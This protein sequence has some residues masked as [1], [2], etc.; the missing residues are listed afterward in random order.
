MYRAS[1]FLISF[2]LLLSLPLLYLLA[3]RVFPPL[4]P[5][6]D[7]I[8]PDDELDDLSLLRRASISSTASRLSSSSPHP[9]FKIAFLFLTHTDLHF[10]PLWHRFFRNHRHRSLFNIYVHAD[11]S[12]NIS[13]PSPGSV[14]H[15]RFIHSKRTYRASPTLIA[16]TRRLLATALLDDPANA[17]FTVLSQYCIPLHSFDYVYRSL[18]TSLTF[19]HSAAAYSTQYGVRLQYRSYIEVLNKSSS[20][21]KRYTARG[22]YSMIP[23]VPFEKFRVGSQFFSLTR[24]HALAVVRDR[25]LW[26]KFKL[27]C[28]SEESCYPEEHYFPTLLSMK[29]PRGLTYYTLTAVNWTGTVKGHP[30]TY[31]PSEISPQLIERLRASNHSESHLF[32]RKFSPDCLEPLMKIASKAIF[33]D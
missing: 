32:A 20:L 13:T 29:D 25:S 21:W 31:T 8:S 12:A 27:P 4:F 23:E 5:L 7:T 19:D 33:Q 22:R 16:A 18:F 9:S 24:G 2:T 11:P 28:Y 14:F 30:H 26:K 3:P 15:G 6:P 10:S 1:P 17:Y